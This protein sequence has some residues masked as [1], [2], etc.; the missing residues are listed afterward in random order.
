MR[1]N[2][3]RSAFTR[4]APIAP[5]VRERSRVRDS[6]LGDASTLSSLTQAEI[7]AVKERIREQMREQ[8]QPD[9]VDDTKTLN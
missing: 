6:W 1:P 5:A 9:A 8:Q 7:D 3:A 4:V 2:S